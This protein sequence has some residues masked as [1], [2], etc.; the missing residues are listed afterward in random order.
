M[1]QEFKNE[2]NDQL[3][4]IVKQKVN[5]LLPLCDSVQIFITKRQDNENTMSMN[6]GEGNWF[7]RY[8]QVKAW[9]I[10]SEHDEAISSDD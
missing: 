9:T 6:W 4:D 1:K 2:Y 5:E 3:L 10:K 7:A 8:G